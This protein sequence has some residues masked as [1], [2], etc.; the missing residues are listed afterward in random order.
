MPHIALLCESTNRLF[1]AQSL[2]Q[3]LQLPLISC[4]DAAYDY[5]LVLTEQQLE[6]RQSTGKTKPIVVDF[7]SP[8]AHFRRLRG[9][10]VRQLIAKAVGIKGLYR[11]T[12]IDATA[13]LGGDSFVLACLGCQVH[14]LERSAVVAALLQDALMRLTNSAEGEK[15]LISLTVT[16]AKAYLNALTPAQ[17][18]DVIY[19]DPMFQH[20]S[21]TALAKKEMRLLRDLVG[22]DM[23]AAQLLAVA[24]QRAN[25]R[26]V[27]KQARHAPVLAGNTPQIV[28]P[29]QSCRFDVYLTTSVCSS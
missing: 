3:Q 6:L 28:F 19:L 7:C 8:A 12:V 23:D 21:K 25:R 27:V 18:P 1:E 2:A 17:A 13:G 5:W 11:P 29:G 20:Q 15:L 9:G 10:G 24:R 16:D 26:V 4:P 14:C 22:A